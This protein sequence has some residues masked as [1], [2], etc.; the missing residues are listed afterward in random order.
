MSENKP[1]G[2]AE[3][4]MSQDPLFSGKSTSIGQDSKGRARLTVSVTQEE[5][6]KIVETLTGLLD[7]PRGIK[8]DFHTGEKQWEGKTFLSTFFYVKAVQDPAT[9]T[10][11]VS[12]NTKP[13]EAFDVQEKIKKMKEA[14]GKAVV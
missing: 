5:A 11:P 10:K 14:M 12:F 9:F 13:K 1:L 3:N 2:K 6:V 8:F 4:G 7:N